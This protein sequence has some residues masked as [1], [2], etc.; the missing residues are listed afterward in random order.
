MSTPP[1]AAPARAPPAP[2]GAR[3]PLRV[4]SS[5]AASHG[6]G[7]TGHGGGGERGARGKPGPARHDTLTTPLAS[8]SGPMMAA[9]GQGGAPKVSRAREM[10]TPTGRP[11]THRAGCRAPHTAGTGPAASGSSCT[12][13]RPAGDGVSTRVAWVA[14]HSEERKEKERPTLTLPAQSSLRMRMRSSI[15]PM[16]QI[17]STSVCSVHTTHTRGSAGLG[18]HQPITRG[19]GARLP[20]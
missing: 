5:R 12:S 4:S 8:S 3:P 17:T 6:S 14:W 15:M 9:A 20:R 18:R 13:F 10:H 11:P 2:C 19:G 1:R 7:D 16:P